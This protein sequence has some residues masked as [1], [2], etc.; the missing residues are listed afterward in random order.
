MGLSQLLSGVALA[1]MA[2][3]QATSDFSPPRRVIF[4]AERTQIS[5]QF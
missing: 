1:L 3:I 2:T 5:G 4:P